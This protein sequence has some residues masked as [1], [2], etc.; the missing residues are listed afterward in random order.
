MQV[1]I[2]GSGVAGLTAGG[3]LARS[4]CK[5]KIFEQFDE[6][7]GV[8]ATLKKDGFAW[9]LGPMLLQGFEP[10]GVGGVIL[11]ELDITDK[12]TLERDDRGIVMPDFE[13]WHPKEYEGPYWRRERLKDIFP[14]ERDGL[15][16]YY[17]FYDQMMDLIALN[18]R[19]TK[20][21]GLKKLFLKLRMWRA[22]APIKHMK[23]WSAEDVMNHF[24][25]GPELKGLYTGILADFV[26][27]P[28]EFIGLGIPAVN[29]ETAFDKRIPLQYTKAGPRPGYNYVIGGCEKL[30]EALAGVV[31]D[32]GGEIFTS[33]PVEKIIVENNK[34][35]GVRLKDGRVEKADLVI[36]SGGA[37]ETYFGL[38][39][40]ENLTDEFIERVDDVPLME[41]VH[42][43]HL[44][45]DFDTLPYQPSALCYYYGTYD[46]ED[47]VKRCQRSQYHEGDDGFLIYVP[48]LHS[49]DM[50]P[51]GHHAVTVYTIAPNNLDTGTWAEREQEMTDKLMEKA[52]KIIPNLR[53][54]AKVTVVM[55]PDD[56][57]KRV[58][59][60]H[61]GF[62][63]RAPVM[64]KKGGPHKP[65]VS[66][67]WFVGS[68]SEK[69]GGGVS[70]TM[71]ASRKVI[72]MINKD[73]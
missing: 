11:D 12:I 54:R 38:V 64:G 61:H 19:A 10:G 49:P 33:S 17:E 37:R 39:G 20:A 67:L 58:H 69:E 3:Y 71:N 48:S 65:P 46:V 40:K 30:V 66:G 14:D 55:T 23:E 27:K 43:V 51:P 16:R 7:G 36:A 60:D 25:K 13:L 42:M 21:K 5:V 15:D 22:F 53:K 73:R 31:T 72:G 68:Q 52:E 70:G 24:F 32:H 1:V 8:T 6:I 57:K 4:G 9:D 41:S 18:Y 28:S 50:A 2:I 59:V 26:V 34:A 63:G 45:I 35:T 44:G 62:G 47:A 56:F 29:I